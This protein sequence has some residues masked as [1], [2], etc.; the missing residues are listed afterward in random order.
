MTGTLLDLTIAGRE[1]TLGCR[2]AHMYSDMTS[3]HVERVPQQK[4]GLGGVAEQGFAMLN[5]YLPE[6]SEGK[7]N[8]YVDYPAMMRRFNVFAS[9]ALQR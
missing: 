4:T 9:I 7:K 8:S 1:F 6:Q 3:I 5:L 2:R